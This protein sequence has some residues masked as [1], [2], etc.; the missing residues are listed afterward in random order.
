MIIIRECYTI[1]VETIIQ[2]Y[3][4]II[5]KSFILS[6][7]NDLLPSALAWGFEW[8]IYSHDVR[9]YV[10]TCLSRLGM[11][12]WRHAGMSRCHAC[13]LRNSECHVCVRMPLAVGA[14]S[15]SLEDLGYIHAHPIAI[16]MYIHTWICW[17]QHIWIMFDDPFLV[18]FRELKL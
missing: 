1:S 17:C 4:A 10:C 5:Q 9:T 16:I 11:L 7:C 14:R 6:T 8:G 12:R 18:H 2:Y 13:G 15:R 3:I